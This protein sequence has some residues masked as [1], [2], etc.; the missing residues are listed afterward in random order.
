MVEIISIMKLIADGATGLFFSGNLGCEWIRIRNTLITIIGIP[1]LVYAFIYLNNHRGTYI[2]TIGTVETI[3][4]SNVAN[5]K[6]TVNSHDYENTIDIT[7]ERISLGNMLIYYNKKHPKTCFLSQPLSTG[8]R[9]TLMVLCVLL[10]MFLLI[11]L[12]LLYTDRKLCNYWGG[13]NNTA[14]TTYSSF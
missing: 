13:V 12:I 8:A 6:Y 4:P 5:V 3:N 10:G 2:S 1:I 14:S 11:S 7:G 9:I